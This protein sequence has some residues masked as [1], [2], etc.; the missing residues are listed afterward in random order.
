M[1]IVNPQYFFKAD[2]IRPNMIGGRNYKAV[3]MSDGKTW[4]AENLDLKWEGLI[5]G[6][7]HT[8]EPR[9]LYYSNN[10]E[11][12]GID[13]ER[14]CGLLYN[15]GAAL[16]LQEHREELCKGWH[17]PT[18][19]DWYGLLTKLNYNAKVLKGSNIDWATDWNGTDDYGFNVLPCGYNNGS[20]FYSIGS[21]ANI[22]SIT[23]S[24]NYYY[25]FNCGKSDTA[26]VNGNHQF[27]C[28]SIR[29]IKD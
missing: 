8:A 26:Y 29:L 4:L 21:N 20:G 3:K 7:S 13:G 2:F 11:T 28:Y 22:W 5:I 6:G 18:V 14:H 23:P 12:Y 25:Y 1:S 10:E 24:G 17:L 16:Y 19:E 9:A 15:I 27:M